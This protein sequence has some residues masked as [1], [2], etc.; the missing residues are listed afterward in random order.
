LDRA[1]PQ[2][3]VE[4]D[5]AQLESVGTKRT[6]EPADRKPATGP[7]ALI[8]GVLVAW[9]LG[10][11]LVST[12]GAAPGVAL[13]LAAASGGALAHLPRATRGGGG[14]LSAR[15]VLLVAGAVF[16]AAVFSLIGGL[17]PATRGNVAMQAAVAILVA[18]LVAAATPLRRGAIPLLLGSVTMVS[19]LSGSAG[20]GVPDVILTVLMAAGATR[21]AAAVARGFGSVASRRGSPESVTPRSLGSGDPECVAT[22]AADRALVASGTP[23]PISSASSAASSSPGDTPGGGGLP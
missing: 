3:H 20:A 6:E 4:G 18:V 5:P 19:A 15:L 11:A 14:T 7:L 21:L 16:S 1:L 9:I 22:E 10:T 13:A 2:L 17:T 12:P 23:A 8:V